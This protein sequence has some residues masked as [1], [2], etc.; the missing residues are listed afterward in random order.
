M[1]YNKNI[2]DLDFDVVT[3]VFEILRNSDFITMCLYDVINRGFNS[4]R[5]AGRFIRL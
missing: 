1:E 2:F 4:S 5:V 3:E